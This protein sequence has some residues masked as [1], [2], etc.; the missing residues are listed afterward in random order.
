MLKVSEE[1]G[2]ASL[3]IKFGRSIDQDDTPSSKVEEL[4]PGVSRVG[5][6]DWDLTKLNVSLE[7]VANE[8]EVHERSIYRAYVDLG[9]SID[10]VCDGIQARE[11]SR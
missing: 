4:S 1:N 7:A 2:N 9:S 11:F 3:S 5:E 6:I 8:L 10:S